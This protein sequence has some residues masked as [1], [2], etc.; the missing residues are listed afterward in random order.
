MP[1]A[2]QK[3]PIYDPTAIRDISQIVYTIRLEQDSPG[4]VKR[5]LELDEIETPGDNGK[6][7][8]NRAAQYD[9]LTRAY[10]EAIQRTGMP[11]KKVR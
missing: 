1:K 7:L 2:G 9:S 4:G 5:M 11:E 8:R 6:R 3:T 10:L